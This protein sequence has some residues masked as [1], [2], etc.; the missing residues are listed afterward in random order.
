MLTTTTSQLQRLSPQEQLKRNFED[1]DKRLDRFRL[2]DHNDLQDVRKRVGQA[3]FHQEFIRRVEKLTNK[4]VWAEDSYRDPLNVAGFYHVKNG[5]KTYICAF[6]KGAMPEF[7]V[8]VTDAAD[9]PIKEKRGWRTVLTRLMQ[10]KA[11]TWPQVVYGFGD[12]QEHAASDR[13][14]FNTREFRAK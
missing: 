10:A 3:L 1:T 2:S 14:S 11:I 4:R 7:S 5:V 9:L 8:I 12:G 6:D 13:W